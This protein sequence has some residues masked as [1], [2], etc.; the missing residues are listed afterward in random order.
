MLNAKEEFQV[1]AERRENFA[2]IVAEPVVA[3]AVLYAIAKFASEG[4]TTEQLIGVRKYLDIFLTLAEPE[5]T[6]LALPD[7]S[8]KTY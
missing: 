4:A 1:S 7:K 5:P 3:I 8:L 2:K 6:P